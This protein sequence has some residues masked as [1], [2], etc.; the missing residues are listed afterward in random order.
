MEPFCT[1]T[2]CVVSCG[3]L[4]TLARSFGQSRLF[5]GVL[6]FCPQSCCTFGRYAMGPG[7]TTKLFDDSD[8]YVHEGPRALFKG[9]GPTL[10]GAVPARFA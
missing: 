7:L 2:A 4:S 1:G 9:L 3:T 5:F 6:H 10:A 8:V